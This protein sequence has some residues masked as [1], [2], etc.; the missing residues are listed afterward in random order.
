[1]KEHKRKKR[2]IIG[3][4]Y[5]VIRLHPSS[6]QYI[7]KVIYKAVKNIHP[8]Q[9]NNDIDSH[10]HH[11]LNYKNMRVLLVTPFQDDPYWRIHQMITEKFRMLVQEVH[12]IKAY[13]GYLEALSQFHPD[14]LLFVGND[15]EIHSEDMHMIKQRSPKT[16]IWLTDQD[17]T[18]E[19]IKQVAAMFDYVFTQNA[20][21]LP[22]YQFESGIKHI[23]H[24][25]FAADSYAYYPKP[26]EDDYKA[27]LLILGDADPR[28]ENFIN[29]LDHLLN[30]KRIFVF[31]KGWNHYEHVI[32]LSTN[33]NLLNYM[34]GAEIIINWNEPIHHMFECAACGGFQITKDHPSVYSF[35]KP[36]EDIVVF[37]STDDLL[38]ILVY[39]FAQ[40]D[41][42]R[43]IATNALQGSLYRFS[44]LQMVSQI[45]YNVRTH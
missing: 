6:Q 24:L 1:M 25:P 13:P 20:A 39:Y 30:G 27:S 21:F 29:K 32:Q 42:K 22:F 16:A 9:Q 23:S 12:A 33:V 26:V 5:P 4:T 34:N 38:D 44:F 40:V 31:G 35:L 19:D 17:G 41:Q 11:I 2:K 7:S 8:A 45:I 15:F 18:S 14:L 37:H 36:G 3:N 28:Y 10:F 43:S